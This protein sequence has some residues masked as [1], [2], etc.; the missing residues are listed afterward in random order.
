VCVSVCVCERA[1]YLVFL[2]FFFSRKIELTSLY[3]SLSPKRIRVPCLMGVNRLLATRS[4]SA[5]SLMLLTLSQTH[6]HTHTHAHML[7]SL[8]L[9]PPPSLPLSPSH[10]YT[11]T[12]VCM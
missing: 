11:Y 2:L 3:S 6:T 1:L 8:S 10:T 9:S 7:L 4:P 5:D 12:Y